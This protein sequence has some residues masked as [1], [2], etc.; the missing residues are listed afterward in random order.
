[1]NAVITGATK[2]IGKAIAQKLALAGYNLA[3]CSRSQSEIDTCKAELLRLNPKVTIAGLQTDCADP[4]Q[5]QRFA[6]FVQQHFEVVDVL[7]NNAG[8]Y[9]PASILDETEDIL[10]LQMQLN[11]NT[12]YQLCRVFGRQMRDNHKGHIINICSVAAIR[13][14]ISAG[15]YTVTKFALLGLTRVLR[16]ELMP[17]HVKVTA[18]LPGSTLTDSWKGTDIPPDR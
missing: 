6:G 4:Q 11:F 5:V 16:E 2:G 9:I 13:P 15:S 3:I 18:I 12:A 1:M 8:T 14:V 17:Y 10:Q 7:V